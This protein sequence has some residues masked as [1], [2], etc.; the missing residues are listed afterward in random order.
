MRQLFRLTEQDLHNIVKSTVLNIIKEGYHDTVS[1][2]DNEKDDFFDPDG[3]PSKVPG[4]KKKGSKKLP[5]EMEGKTS[6]HTLKEDYP[7]SPDEDKFDK[8]ER[9]K[10]REQEIED[11]WR[12]KNERL[13]A[14]YPGR[15]REWYEAM[16]DM[17]ENTIKEDAGAGGGATNC[18]GT[19]QTGSGNAPLGT[20]PE[21]GQY[22]VPFGPDKET[23]D[24]T[25]G[26]SVKGKAVGKSDVQRRQI[27]NPKSGK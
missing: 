7:F 27:Y 26:F 22:T 9:Q 19:M 17:F 5:F 6:R 16:I 20:N 25:P 18:A 15:S 14:K 23:S 3:N 12:D 10:R 4:K 2:E 21:A 8:I 13:R 24:R 1:D 11:Y